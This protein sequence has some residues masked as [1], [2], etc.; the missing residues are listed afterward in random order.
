MA[1]T[2]KADEATMREICRYGTL[3][4]SVHN[5]QPWRFK[6][7]GPAI[8]V[9]VDPASILQEGDPT[10]RELWLSM[11]ACLEN[12]CLAAGSLGYKT[13]LKTDAHGDF[14]QRPVAVLKLSKSAG[15]DKE[16]LKAIEERVSD[17]F[18]YRS[19][20]VSQN[21]L[22]KI[23][24]SWQSKSVKVMA[25]GDPELLTTL[26][27]LTEKGLSVALGFPGFRKELSEL[28]HFNWQRPKVGMPGY[29]LT[30]GTLGSVLEKAS[31]ATGLGSR[32]KA[33]ED[34]RLIAA[35]PAV[36]MT[37]TSGDT[38]LYWLEAGRAFQHAL[39]QAALL[40]LHTA[41]VAAVVE[42]GD[43]HEDIEALAG[44]AWRLQTVSRAGYPTKQHVP[45]SPR[46]PLEE[47][48]IT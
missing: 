10:R 19:K 9:F 12:L 48:I 46:L 26:G 6:L 21:L 28:V 17:R 23:S 13:G 41:T 34:G 24:G 33:V 14:D 32:K 4:P 43:F 20:P 30:R 15:G 1:M 3:A 44:T 36:I 5:T 8:E 39:L 27:E 42:A 7:A 16:W 35:G 22:N 38:P 2:S 18:S 40:G 31:L 11:G 47:V 29:T 37:F 25:T 45:H